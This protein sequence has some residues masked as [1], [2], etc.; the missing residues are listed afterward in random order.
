MT[1]QRSHLKGF[2]EH[3]KLGL[4][5]APATVH[6]YRSHVRRYLD[7]ATSNGAARLAPQMQGEA[8]VGDLRASGISNTTVQ[9]HLCSLSAFF[10]Y[11]SNLE[12]GTLSPFAGVRRP[13]REP[14]IRILLP[15]EQVDRLIEGASRNP[16]SFRG[17][18]DAAIISAMAD[19]GLRRHEVTLVDLAGVTRRADGADLEVVGKGRKLRRIPCP[20]R[21]LRLLDTW[22]LVRGTDPGPL[23]VS[24]H[25]GRL[26]PKSIPPIL[27]LAAHLAGLPPIHCHDLRHYYATTLLRGG[28]DLL[29]IQEALGH[30]SPVTTAAYLHADH[31]RSRQAILAALAK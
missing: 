30:S 4:G 15:G 10:R 25:R 17:P 22:L 7:W 23:F 6:T 21:L 26:S 11:L 27:E 18:R 24:I 31:E 28:A 13:R 1:P 8:Y 12:P 9:S 2:L 3:A 29:S 16:Y 5:V 20:P 19:A 14:V